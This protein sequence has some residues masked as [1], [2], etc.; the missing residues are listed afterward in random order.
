MKLTNG[1][2]AALLTNILTNPNSG[3]VDSIERFES[4]FTDLA[5]VV[6]D[7]CGGDVVVDATYVGMQ[8]DDEFASAY[9]I[10]VE[11]NES[12]PEHGGVWSVSSVSQVLHGRF[13]YEGASLCADFEVPVGATM[14]QKDAAFLAA[15]AQKAEVDYL[16]VGET[17]A[18]A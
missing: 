2:L 4:F 13:D 16:V 12:S 15:L 14:A 1:A 9:V 10:E 8:N 3:E 6:C 7:H 11:P 5:N 17:P 18:T